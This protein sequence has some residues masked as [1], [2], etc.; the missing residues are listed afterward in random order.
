VPGEE[1]PGLYHDYVRSGDAYRLVP[2]FH[3]NLLD[4]VTMAGVLRALCASAVLPAV[5]SRPPGC[6]A[7]VE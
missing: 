6:P 5:R 4:V 7:R 1:V 2:V 3:H